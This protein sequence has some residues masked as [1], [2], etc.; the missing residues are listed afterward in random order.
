MH[1]FSSTGEIE[2][3]FDW[4]TVCNEIAAGRRQWEMDYLRCVAVLAQIDVVC[5]SFTEHPP[6]EGYTPNQA[7]LQIY[8]SLLYFKHDDDRILVYDKIHLINHE[9]PWMLFGA[10]FQHLKGKDMR[11]FGPAG[12][13][14]QGSTTSSSNAPAK[15]GNVLN[16]AVGAAYVSVAVPFRVQSIISSTHRGCVHVCG[17]EYAAPCEWAF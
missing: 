11:A 15:F 12:E 1:T 17:C 14:A 4:N 5:M 7:R 6:A 3:R 8:N 13:A 10:P 2:R 16:L 9:A